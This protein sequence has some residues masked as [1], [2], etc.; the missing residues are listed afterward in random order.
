MLG[1]A[2]T[3]E[4]TRNRDAQGFGENKQAAIDDGSVAGTARRDLETKSG[5]KVVSRKNYLP[6][7]PDSRKLPK[8]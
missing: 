4:I 2:A 8:S 1:E 3:T 5:K 6:D 7:K